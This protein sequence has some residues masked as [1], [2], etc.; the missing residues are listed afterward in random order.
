MNI[1]DLV[2]KFL[3]EEML[4]TQEERVT[5]DTPLVSGGLV[6]SFT[7]VALLEHIERATNIRIPR[8]H[9][10]KEDLDT[11]RSIE[12]VINLSQRKE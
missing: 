1:T 10:T 3:Q 4:I 8:Q 7:L 2:N 12:S 11:I 5:E 9:L 6:D